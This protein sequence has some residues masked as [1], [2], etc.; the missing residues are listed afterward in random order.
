[1]A[2]FEIDILLH[3]AT[4]RSDHPLMFNP[5]PIWRETIERFIELGLLEKAS[6]VAGDACYAKTARLD[7]YSEALQRVPLPVQQWVT[8]NAELTGTTR[9]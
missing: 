7:A 2:P 4:T 6:G 3:Y 8:P 9:R 5:P 1:M